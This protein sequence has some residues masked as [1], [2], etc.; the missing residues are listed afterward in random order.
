[1]E[2][3]ELKQNHEGELNQLKERLRKEKH[4]SSTAISEQISQV[5]R[6]LEDQWRTRSDRLVTQAE[7]RA[8]RKYSDLQDEYKMLQTQL[9]EATLKV[10]GMG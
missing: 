2:V 5:E 1:M 7:E 8:R 4:S 6:D 10:R 3:E 9:S